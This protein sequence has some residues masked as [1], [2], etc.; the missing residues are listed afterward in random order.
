[1]R[2]AI[3]VSCR[4]FLTSSFLS[5]L[6]QANEKTHTGESRRNGTGEGEEKKKKKRLAR[7]S[8]PSGAI[9]MC[10]FFPSLSSPE[11]HAEQSAVHISIE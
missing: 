6:A 3:A 5:S 11:T 4:L 1:V 2:S 8:K 7:E 10:N 9:I